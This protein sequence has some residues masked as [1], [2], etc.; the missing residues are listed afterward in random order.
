MS[1][2]SK[3]WEVALAAGAGRGGGGGDK[4]LDGTEETLSTQGQSVAGIAV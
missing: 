4:H 2:Y 1:A 3:D